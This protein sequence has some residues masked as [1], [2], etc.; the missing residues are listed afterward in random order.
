MRKGRNMA[1]KAVLTFRL[2]PEAVE[3]ETASIKQDIQKESREIIRA[4]PWAAEIEKI[5]VE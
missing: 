4:V 2:V 3:A 1:R 5:Q